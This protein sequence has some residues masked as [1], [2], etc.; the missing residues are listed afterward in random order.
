MQ[1]IYIL[2]Y[3]WDWLEIFWIQLGY[4]HDQHEPPELIATQ[5]H[6]S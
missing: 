3:G 6:F 4:K 5:I 2:Y 1:S